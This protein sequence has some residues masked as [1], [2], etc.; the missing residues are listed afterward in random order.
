MEKIFEV[1]FKLTFKLLISLF[2]GLAKKSPQ[3]ID[4]QDSQT[5]ASPTKPKNGCI[6]LFRWFTVGVTIFLLPIAVGHVISFFCMLAAIAILLPPLDSFFRSKIPLL[7]NGWLKTLLWIILF[8]TASI[9]ATEG[10]PT[11][12]ELTLCPQ[13]QSG[14]CP[15][16]TSALVKDTPKLY[17]T[18]TS[19]HIKDGAE[20]EMNLKYTSEPNQE[21][22]LE[23]QT[24]QANV[25]NN[26][27]ILEIKPK[28]L[29]IGAYQLSI[30]STQNKIPEKTKT[31]T[32]WDNKKNLEA[33]TSDNLSSTDVSFSGFKMCS[34]ADFKAGS[35]NTAI[36]DAEFQ[37][38]S[39]NTPYRHICSTDST[40]FK[41]DVKTLNF[42][43]DFDSKI[44]EPMKLRI[45]WKYLKNQEET[46]V[47]SDSLKTLDSG[48]VGLNYTLDTKDGLPVG[49][50]ELILASETKNA[51]PIY[52]RFT[53]E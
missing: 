13:L 7:Q 30:T 39:I 12:R 34:N 3:K 16:D 20:F 31:F 37:V 51:M 17:L 36:G 18:G 27:L 14:V 46:I 1:I 9:L 38:E 43:L 41:P 50:Y 2:K 10:S 11:V 42:S 44:V 19:E 6:T 49:M 29:P 21:S 26:Q 47:V 53:V 8:F 5:G 33:R 24:L 25:K 23:S 15:S 4:E 32:V 22:L 45:T 35:Q 40:S 52:R 28:Q 48:W